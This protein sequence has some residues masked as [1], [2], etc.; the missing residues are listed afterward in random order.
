MSAEDF[1]E[2]LNN[3]KIVIQVGDYHGL[4]FI[5]YADNDK[6]ETDINLSL[7][8]EQTEFIYFYARMNFNDL[9]TAVESVFGH[10]NE[11]SRSVKK[12]LGHTPFYEVPERLSSPFPITL[13]IFMNLVRDALAEF[14]N[15]K[16]KIIHYN[17]SQTDLDKYYSK[18]NRDDDVHSYESL[19][20]YFYVSRSVF[21]CLANKNKDLIIDD[22]NFSEFPVIILSCTW[23]RKLELYDLILSEIPDEITNLSNLISLS[24]KL[25]FLEKL[26]ASIFRLSKLEVLKIERTNI[27]ELSANIFELTN[28]KELHLINNQELKELPDQISKLANLEFLY[29]YSNKIK[30]LPKTIAGLEN[31]RVLYLTGNIIED[32]PDE[33]TASPKLKALDLSGNRL[34]AIPKDL[35]EMETLEEINLSNNPILDKDEVYAL[36][37]KAGRRNKINVVL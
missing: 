17:I 27:S 6:Y 30:T 3:P 4:I 26:P 22:Y 19:L 21:N 33:I 20:N 36:L 14:Y 12:M 9:Y 7:F 34:R 5:E 16:G 31:L 2:V 18:P 37:M 29:V 23:I 1:N 13:S 28:L 32:L 25:K 35:F 24:L 8:A 11:S 10:Y 15:V